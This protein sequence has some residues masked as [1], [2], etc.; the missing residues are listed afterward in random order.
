VHFYDGMI[1]AAAERAG[2]TRILSEELNAGQKYLGVK[3]ANPF[4]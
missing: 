1:A 2:C 4:V 3:V